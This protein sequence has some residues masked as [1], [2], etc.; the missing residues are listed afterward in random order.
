[1]RRITRAISMSGASPVPGNPAVCPSCGL[2]QAGGRA[3][4]SRCGH[5]LHPAGFIYR[6][7]ANGTWSIVKDID[8]SKLAPPPRVQKK[9][10]GKTGGAI[11][12]GLILLGAALNIWCWTLRTRDTSLEASEIENYLDHPIGRIV[13][14]F[15][16]QYQRSESGDLQ[17]SGKCNLPDG[18]ALE[19]Q[20][21]SGDLLVAVDYPVT[22]AAGMFQTRPL[23]QR[24]KPFVPASYKLQIRAT[25]EKRWQPP[26]GLLVVGGRGERLEGSFMHRTERSS[27]STLEFTEDFT[28]LQ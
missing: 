9:L 20:V 16:L 27:G 24:G 15:K 7:E 12:L 13:P 4:C 23:L 14:R 18:T 19:V 25:F 28:L 3:E 26:F 5:P 10:I 11:V 22:V 2:T 1:M 17:V 21:Y 8:L 6:R